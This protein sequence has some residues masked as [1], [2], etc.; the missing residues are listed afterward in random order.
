VCCRELK[1]EVLEL[2]SK[3]IFL[4]GCDNMGK[5]VQCNMLKSYLENKGHRVLLTCSPGGTSIS[6]HIRNILLN[7]EIIN[8]SEDMDY[9]TKRALYLASFIQEMYMVNK[10]SNE[11]DFI[12][13]DRY[14]PLSDIAYGYMMED[15]PFKRSKKQEIAEMM[16]NVWQYYFSN[17]DHSLL[18]DSVLI[19]LHADYSVLKERENIR[20]LQNN[21]PID[22]YDQEDDDFKYH[23]W[24][25]YSS[26]VNLLSDIRDTNEKTFISSFIL[27]RT[28][29]VVNASGS[30]ND[31]TRD[32]L[33]I[34]EEAH[35]SEI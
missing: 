23:I 18:N 7:P 2:S 10:T 24:S 19:I 21:K 27:S 9:L 33:N 22:I 14:N 11:Y 1:K 12:I 8:T 26:I 35:I 4:D 16:R 6:S 34:L 3:L 28:I 5:S 30:A 17:Y 29:K 13:C 31:V 20:R 32:I 15:R 25:N